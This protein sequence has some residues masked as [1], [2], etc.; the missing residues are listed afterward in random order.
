M[1]IFQRLSEQGYGFQKL[2]VSVQQALDLFESCLE[3]RLWVG[4][5]EAAE[6]FRKCFQPSLRSRELCNLVYCN[7]NENFGLGLHR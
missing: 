7:S 4:I 5:F 1:G 2:P 3:L 6:L